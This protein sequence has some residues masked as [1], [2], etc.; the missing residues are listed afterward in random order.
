MERAGRPGSRPWPFPAAWTAACSRNSPAD[1]CR[2]DR[3]PEVCAV[4][5]DSL[6]PSRPATWKMPGPRGRGSSAR[7]HEILRDRTS[8]SWTKSGVPRSTAATSANAICSGLL[9]VRMVPGR[10]AST[11]CSGRRQPGRPARVPPGHPGAERSWESV[12]P[13][14]E[15]GHHQGGGAADWPPPAALSASRPS[16][17]PPAWPPACPTIRLWMWRR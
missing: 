15:A 6:P 7:S 8:W 17:P 2:Q 4:T 16:L 10:G 9:I 14:A 1:Q 3:P 11:L 13:L 12:S 5:F